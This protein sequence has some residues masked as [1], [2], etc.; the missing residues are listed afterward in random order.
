MSDLNTVPM[1]FMKLLSMRTALLLACSIQSLVACAEPAST[2]QNAS[3]LSAMLTV[4]GPFHVG[5]AVTYVA[6]I[7]NQS[8]ATQPDLLDHEFV[9]TIPAGIHA[10]AGSVN[11]TTGTVVFDTATR[12]F[13]WDGSLVSGQ[14]VHIIFSATI[15]ANTEGEVISTQGTAFYV[16][17]FDGVVVQV[18]TDD[19]ALPGDED[20]TSFTVLGSTPVTL[21]SF[22]VR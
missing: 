1:L 17:D 8:D 18:P 13:G 22:D 20:S 11:A 2:P 9:V 10:V 3:I 19:P 6:T 21:Q 7:T 16:T 15:D 14:A 5:D 4:S 12:T